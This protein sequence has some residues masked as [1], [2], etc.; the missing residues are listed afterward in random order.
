M[1]PLTDK[2]TT[3]VRSL[4]KTVAAA[5]EQTTSMAQ[6]R[7]V[8]LR[9]KRPATYEIITRNHQTR[10]PADS[11]RHEGNSAGRCL[12]HTNIYTESEAVCISPAQCR[13]VLERW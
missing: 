4:Y 9:D 2:Q 13:L 10:A 3:T 1:K 12:H 6:H 5:S 8:G 11:A 7:S